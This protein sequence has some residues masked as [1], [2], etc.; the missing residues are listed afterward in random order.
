M[1]YTNGW[2]NSLYSD[3]LSAFHDARSHRMHKLY[4]LFFLLP[5]LTLATETPTSLSYA[6]TAYIVEA[7]G[8]GGEFHFVVKHKDD[9]HG[10]Q[11][12]T[13]SVRNH[14]L[15]FLANGTW[16]GLSWMRNKEK[17][18]EGVF[19]IGSTEIIEN[20][21]AILYDPKSEDQVSLSCSKNKD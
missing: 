9:S 19:V 1:K 7:E 11:E 13:Y 17:I 2:K 3:C 12:L 4:L 16:L 10:G 6:C 14:E 20:R 15:T 8:E 18:A 21:V 5:T